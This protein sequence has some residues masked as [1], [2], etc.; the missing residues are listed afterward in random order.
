MLAA[1]GC[2]HAM[3]HSPVPFL[4][5]SITGIDERQNFVAE[6]IPVRKLACPYQIETVR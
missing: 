3:A 6:P 2:D 4:R 1:V 5:F